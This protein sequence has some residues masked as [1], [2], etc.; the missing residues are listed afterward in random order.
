MNRETPGILFQQRTKTHKH[1]KSN[2]KVSIRFAHIDNYNFLCVN[3][4]AKISRYEECIEKYWN[5]FVEA[6][7]EKGKVEDTRY[8]YNKTNKRIQSLK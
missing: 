4:V 1:L 6:W 5:K 7:F 3:A 8:W 2:N